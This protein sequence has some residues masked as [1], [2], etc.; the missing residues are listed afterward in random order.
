MDQHWR[1]LE[2]FSYELSISYG[3]SFNP[4]SQLLQNR[5]SPCLVVPASGAFVLL[6]HLCPSMIIR[7]STYY[8]HHD[9]LQLVPLLSVFSPFFFFFWWGG[10]GC[11]RVRERD[12][13]IT[14]SRY[15]TFTWMTSTT[16]TSLVELHL[17]LG[18]WSTGWWD[19]W[20]VQYRT[21][22]LH[23]VYVLFF[24]FNSWYMYWA[25]SS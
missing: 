23:L 15:H 16:R 11:D 2:P 13:C 10:G 12:R 18:S 3:L 8:Y 19:L 1:G 4:L 5:P 7:W 22:S 25:W 24:F 20:L 17:S 21:P 6:Y 9:K 14:F